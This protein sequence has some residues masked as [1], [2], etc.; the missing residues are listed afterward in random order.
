VSVVGSRLV[1]AGCGAS[2]RDDEPY[3]FRC[4]N[5]ACGDDVDHVLRRKLDGPAGNGPLQALSGRGEEGDSNP[6]VRFRGLLRAHHVARAHGVSDDRFV[7]LVRDLDNRVAAVDGHGFV[8][9]PFFRS[10]ELSAALGFSEAGGVWVK[11]ETGNVSGSHKARHLFGVLLWLEVAELVGLADRAA[12]PRLAI[13]SCGNAALAA[14]FVARAGERE[15]EVFVPADADPV[16]LDQ[17]ESLEALVTT[18]PR[19]GLPGDPTYRRLLRA[20]EDGAIPFTCQGNLNGL[21]VEAGQTLGWEIVA[22]GEPIDRLVVQVGGG[23]LASSCIHAFREGAALGALAAIPRIDTVQTEGAWPLRRA[24]DELR[25]VADP[26]EAIRFASHHRSAFMWPWEDEPHSIAHGILD[27]ETYDWLAVVEGMLASGGDA[28]VVDEAA[29][30]AANALARETTAIAVDHTG[31][32][33]LAGVLV[34][35]ATGDVGDDDRVAVLFTGAVR[36][37]PPER[38]ERDE[39]LPRT[40]HPVAEGLRAG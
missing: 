32:S 33:G 21:A 22:A 23:A 34:Q 4:P 2:P 27:D 28:L 16:V 12:R 40:R 9:T 8:A 11:D 5:A 35:R 19:D 20:V 7:E 6:Y 15:L 25:R 10:A 39:E 26:A 24:F 36:T 37:A 18:C 30:E 14:A 29:L 31:T 1:C 3:P 38:R 17:L 13:A